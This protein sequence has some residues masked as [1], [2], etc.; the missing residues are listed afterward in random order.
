MS[1]AWRTQGFQSFGG[2]S[3]FGAAEPEQ[4]ERPPGV[5]DRAPP[6]SYAVASVLDGDPGA[7]VR[8][9]GLTMLRGCFIVPG[10]WV[11]SRLTKIDLEPL[12]ILSLSFGGSATISAGMLAY[13][14]IQRALGAQGV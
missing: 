14:A 12:Q 8:L 2:H 4:Q 11:A 3:G 6:S 7:I 13:Y 1:R 10:M 5:E 9:A